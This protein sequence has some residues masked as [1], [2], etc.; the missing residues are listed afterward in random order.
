MLFGGVVCVR[1]FYKRLAYPM[2][3][4]ALFELDPRNAK[5]FTTRSNE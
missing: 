5:T 1:H 4:D 2:D 3:R